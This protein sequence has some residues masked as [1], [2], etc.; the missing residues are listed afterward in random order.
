MQF[1][2]RYKLP[3]LDDDDYAA[4]ALYMQ[5]MAQRIDAELT[6]RG[7]LLESFIH[8]PTAIWKTTSAQTGIP[9]NAWWLIMSPSALYTAQNWP[10]AID[11][12]P[13]LPPL[14]GWWQIVANTNLVASG[15][16]NFDTQRTLRIDVY[17]PIGSPVG[18][19]PDQFYDETWATNATGGDY[20][21][22][23]AIVYNDPITD[24]YRTRTIDCFVRHNNTSSTLNSSQTPPT[25]VAVTYLGDTPEIQAVV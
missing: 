19:P 15:G 1:T 25:T 4:Y 6:S 5:C 12:T 18:T 14:R 3:C 2:D 22:A 21:L 16:V 23:T 7:D 24:W 10:V 20:L 9:D 17:P 8:R 11:N 13:S